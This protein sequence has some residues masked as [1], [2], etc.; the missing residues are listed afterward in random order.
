ME[1]LNTFNQI[2]KAIEE[3]GIY[4]R[5]KEIKAL[6]IAYLN[7]INAVLVG[8]PGLAKTQLIIE[9]ANL[10]GKKVFT[11]Q[12][13]KFTEYS[14]LFG[15]FDIKKFQEGVLERVI[16]M[17]DADIIYFDEIFKANTAIMNSLLSLLRERKI[18]DGYK[19]YKF[20]NLKTI[21]GSTNYIQKRDSENEAFIDRFIIQVKVNKISKDTILKVIEK[22]TKQQNKTLEKISL[23]EEKIKEEI[24]KEIEELTKSQE[25]KKSL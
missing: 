21:L 4:E 18:F 5:E 17:Q 24:N 11:Y 8:E 13:N 19:E 20:K 1:T 10:I 7:E 23:N 2:K 3:K 9:F 6:F 15:Y 12:L 25:F 22:Q 16:K 14:E